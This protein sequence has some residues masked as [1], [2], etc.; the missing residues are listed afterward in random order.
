MVV[1]LAVAESSLVAM[2]LSSLRDWEM[3]RGESVLM[4]SIASP[5]EDSSIHS[6]CLSSLHYVCSLDPT[7]LCLCVQVLLVPFGNGLKVSK[8]L[9]YTF[10]FER[11]VEVKVVD[12]SNGS[13]SIN[14]LR[15]E[16]GDVWDSYL[17]VTWIYYLDDWLFGSS[18]R[19][20]VHV[21][22]I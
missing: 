11:K 20:V 15:R 10:F 22:G 13:L 8:R 5:L 1:L 2:L 16:Y 6:L 17:K 14:Y 3:Q 18:N 4:T 19:P 12:K 21:Q 7:L 9:F